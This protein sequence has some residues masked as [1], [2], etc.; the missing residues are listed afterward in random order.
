MFDWSTWDNFHFLRPWWLLGLLPL[1]IAAL[2]QWRRQRTQARWEGIIHP[3][4]LEFLLVRG[5][6]ARRITPAS[7]GL[8]AGVLAVLAAA[9]PSW[10]QQASELFNDEAALVIVLDV[11]RSMEA[12]DVQPSRLQR[13]KQKIGDLLKLRG[14]APTALIAYAGTA[15]T[16]IPLTP[17]PIIVEHL[18]PAITPRIMPVAGKDAGSA[19]PVIEQVLEGRDAPATILLVSDATTPADTAAYGKF[20]AER[21]DQLLVWGIGTPEAETLFDREALETLAAS[22]GG[23][24]QALTLNDSDAQ[25]IHART[26]RHL[27]AARNDFAPWVDDGYLLVAPLALLILL[28]FRRGWALS[29]E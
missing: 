16:A 1:V 5:S 25:R 18:L 23:R 6:S 9:G 12:T 7:V 22:S 19:L 3:Q 4:L 8:V 10:R 11:S 28:W 15:H 14:G 2:V 17:D 21:N 24:F 27:V 29:W 26:N 20:F 13:A